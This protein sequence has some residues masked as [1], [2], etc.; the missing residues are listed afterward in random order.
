MTAAAVVGSS[1]AVTKGDET[2]IAWGPRTKAADS[3]AAKYPH[4]SNTKTYGVVIT[5]WGTPKAVETV[6]SG[7]NAASISGLMK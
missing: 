1:V 6:L 2:T 3:Y 4:G 5:A 7:V